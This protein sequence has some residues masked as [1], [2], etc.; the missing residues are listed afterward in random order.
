MM[1]AQINAVE[2]SP[3]TRRAT[4]VNSHSPSNSSNGGS[5]RA[6]GLTAHGGSIWYESTP[7]ANIESDVFT[8][9][10]VQGIPGCGFILAPA[11]NRKMAASTT[12]PTIR[13]IRPHLRRASLL[14]VVGS[15]GG[16]PTIG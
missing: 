13:S 3:E 14:I 16:A 4:P 12:R 5:N 6:N 15:R 9:A 11:A 7:I 1:K 8:E 10:A 2:R